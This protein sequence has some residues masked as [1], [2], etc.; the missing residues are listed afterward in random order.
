MAFTIAPPKIQS[1]L[2]V[3][4]PLA[5]PN[6][7]VTSP[8]A[9]PTLQVTP[10]PVIKP[11]VLPQRQNQ[12]AAVEGKVNPPV[13]R[14]P[15]LPK[16]Q[17]PVNPQP[18]NPSNP[19]RTTGGVDLALNPDG[20][21]RVANPTQAPSPVSLTGGDSTSSPQPIISPPA[22][23][24]TSTTPNPRLAQLQTIQSQISS[25]SKPTQAETDLEAQINAIISP[26]EQRELSISR[27]EGQGRGI[28]QGI[29]EGEQQQEIKTA[30]LQRL[31]ALPLQRQLALLQQQ[32][33]AQLQSAQQQYGFETEALQREQPSLTSVGGSLLRYNPTT[34]K[35][36][37][38]FSAPEK[39]VSLGEGARLVDPITGKEI[40]AGAPKP[41]SPITLGEGQRLV[42]PI[43]GKTIIDALT[44]TDKDLNE[45]LTPKDLSD[46]GIGMENYGLTKGQAM[47]KLQSGELKMPQDKL[48]K[49][50]IDRANN[51]ITQVDD[52]LK[53]V[54]RWTTGVGGL[55]SF[56][57]ESDAQAFAKKIE[58][59]KAN[60]G[61][62]ELQAM[63]QASPTG[64]ALGQVAVQEL[65]FLQAVLG[66]LEP[67][68]KPAVVKANLESIRTHFTNWKKAVEEANKNT[69]QPTSI[70][71]GMENFNF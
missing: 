60:I 70:T 8:V 49:Y 7:R 10:Q 62:N 12:L 17:A 25:Y 51:V 44:G 16:P 6:L 37:T 65:N 27:L 46:L 15:V 33:A 2:K 58:S 39:P 61:F 42:D 32:R 28:P 53:N 67:T 66:S 14:Q 69:N 36:E 4:Q 41:V 18:V 11:S 55:L 43:T 21:M 40:A 63:R 9:Q 23:P 47:Q 13:V 5:Q 22:T 71:P 29:I 57:P 56:I 54:N 20:T 64:G 68:Q 1:K 19:M 30:A 34:G 45:L 3:T 50:N 31:K 38:L 26:A 59:I 24:E 35:I 48:V 52:A